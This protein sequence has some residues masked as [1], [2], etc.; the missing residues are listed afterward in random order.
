L[1]R[2]T[3]SGRFQLCSGRQAAHSF[4]G[5]IAM[6]SLAR[7]ERKAARLVTDVKDIDLDDL[8]DQLENLRDYVHE[9]SQNVGKSASRQ[10]GRARAYTSEAAQE[11]EELMKDNLAASLILALGLGLVVGYLI[12]RSTE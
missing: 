11:A 2:K 7:A 9:L 6:V 4:S 5:R 10:Y 1:E 12:R 8:Y 3:V